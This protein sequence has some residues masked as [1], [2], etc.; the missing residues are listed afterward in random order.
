MQNMRMTSSVLSQMTKNVCVLACL[1]F[2]AITGVV[3][4]AEQTEHVEEIQHE[5]SQED[6][7]ERPNEEKAEQ[8]KQTKKEKIKE[9]AIQVQNPVSDLVRF[10]FTNVMAFGAAPNNS[11]INIFNLN[12]S[13]TRK[14]GQWAIL[15]RLV[16]PLVYLPASVPDALSGDSGKS[17]GLG[18]IEYTAFFA[19]DESKRALKSIGG[20]GP[21][22]IFPTATDDRM[23]LGKWSIGPT[24]AL[25]RMPDPWVHGVVLRNLWSFAGDSDRLKVN[26]FVIRPFVNYNFDNGWYLTS[27]PGI[28]ANW[29]ADG[30]NRWTV[31]IGGGI[32]K[33]MFRG[34]R[35]PV[36]LKLQSFYFIEKPDNAPDWSLNIE[37]RILFPQ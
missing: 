31:P 34:E 13:T 1:L 14:F 28:F 7:G 29:E 19:R 35:H 4:S 8:D 30:R 10:G 26:V 12:A 25:V 15:N 17:F 27:T 20:I 22:F 11:N 9:L 6:E 21:T 33:V 5:A 18:D 24:L 36:D 3:H 32:G 2:F 37:F 16:V 23:G